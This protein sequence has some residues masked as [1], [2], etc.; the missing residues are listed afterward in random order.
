TLP[1]SYAAAA[2]AGMLSALDPQQ[3]LTNKTVAVDGLEKKFAPDKLEQLVQGRVCALED[4]QG[5]RVVR[6]ITTDPGAFQQITTR[7]IVDYAKYGVRGAAEPFI[8]L[9]NNDRVRKALKGAINGFLARMVD[10]EM[11]E[12]YELDVTATRAEEIAGIARVVMTL[13]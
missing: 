3:S 2:I 7:R 4:H 12:S 5:L 10:A 1:G 8:G 6:G 13:R 9:L 11:L